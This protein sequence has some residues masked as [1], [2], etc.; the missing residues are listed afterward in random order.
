MSKR[1]LSAVYISIYDATWKL[2]NRQARLFMS[3]AINR[4]VHINGLNEYG[5]RLKRE[6]KYAGDSDDCETYYNEDGHTMT[7]YEWAGYT[8]FNITDFKEDDF[9]SALLS[10]EMA[11]EEH[12][13]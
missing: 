2:S 5:K 7:R 4:R 9:R 8:A 11:R 13:A 3:D 1:K 12:A 10:L 6:T